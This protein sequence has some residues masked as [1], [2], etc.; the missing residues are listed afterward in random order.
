MAKNKGG[1]ATKQ[2]AA[3]KVKKLKISSLVEPDY[4]NR[5]IADAA[6]QGLAQSLAD[7]GL[8]ALPVVNV[9]GGR[10]IVVGGNQRVRI[11]REAGDEEV[12]CGE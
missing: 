4:N 2:V 6:L 9:K 5:T 12:S 11:L 8:V 3:I 1:G 7:F 10:N